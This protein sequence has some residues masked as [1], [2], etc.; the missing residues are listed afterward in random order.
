MYR[1]QAATNVK[2]SFLERVRSALYGV[3][4]RTWHIETAFVAIVLATVAMATGAKPV[5]WLGSL[6]V[7]AGFGHASIGVRMAEREAQ[8]VRPSVECHAKQVLYYVAK[9]L[10]WTAYFISTHS[11]SALVG[12]GVFLA[13]PIW[14]GIW[15]R[16]HPV[17]A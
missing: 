5:E 3:Q 7:L 17:S 15:R 2:K 10:L 16:Y 9:E 11:W 6:A 1:T 4:I 13:Y 8:R 12:C 14:R